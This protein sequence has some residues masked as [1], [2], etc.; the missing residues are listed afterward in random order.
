MA[1]K[2]K[3]SLAEIRLLV[4]DVDGVLTDGTVTISADGR[5][6]KSFNILDQHGIRLWKRAGLDIAFLSGRVSEPTNWHARDLQVEHVFEN[7]HH[8]LPVVEQLVEKLALS[9]HQVAYVGDD[10]PDL[11]P[12][13]YAGFAVAV[14]N[15]VEEVKQHAD[16]VTTRRGGAG[17]VREVI[18][19]ILKAAG[20]W[21]LLM[22]RYTEN[23]QN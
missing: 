13:R 12:I 1:Q 14:A 2:P 20:K 11:P 5:E 23:G 6:G 21:Q 16:Y 17:A 22:K 3:A 18:E 7:C 19:H 15:A 8:K 4:L 10:L 9:P